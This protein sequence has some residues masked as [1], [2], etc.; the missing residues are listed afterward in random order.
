MT[1]ITIPDSVTSI[2]SSAFSGCG[3]LTSITIPDSVTSIGRYAFSGCGGLTSVT[4]D[5]PTGWYVTRTQGA[6]SGT[7]VN[8][9][10]ASTNANYFTSTYDDYYWY[11]K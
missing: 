4:F 1:S 2:G 7:Y 6:T 3:G 10:N 5:D 8:L 9:I 11:K